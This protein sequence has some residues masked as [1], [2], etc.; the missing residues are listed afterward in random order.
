MSKSKGNVV[1]PWKAIEEFGADTI[2]WYLLSSSH[3]WLPKRFDPAGVREVHRKVFDTLRS[4]YHFFAL[5]ANLEGWQESWQDVAPGDRP[6]MDRWLLSR[7]AQVTERVCGYYEEYNLTHAAREL[8]DFVV[9]DLSNW[10]VR[11]SRDRFWGSSDSRD[12]RAAFATLHRALVDVSRLMAPIAPFLSDWLHRSL[13]GGESVHLARVP[14]VDREVRDEALEQGMEAVR[15]LATL[16]RAARETVRIRVRQPLATLYAVV[17]DDR[18]LDGELLAILRDELN[19]RQVEFMDRAEELV[20]FS[21]KPNFRALGAR[22]GKQ[23]P[24][25]AE[26][27]RGVPSA[28]LAT[29]RRGGELAVELNGDRHSILPA[30]LDIVQTARG[31]LVVEA[32][33]GF[34]AALDANITPELRAEGLAREVVNRVQRLRK[35]SGLEVADRIRLAVVGGEELVAALRAHQPFLAGE[36]LAT[37]VELGAGP[38]EEGSYEAIREVDLDGV[39]AT[40]GISRSTD[41]DGGGGGGGGPGDRASADREEG[42]KALLYSG[43]V[44]GVVGLDQ[45]TKYVVERTLIL[46]NPVPV[47]GDYLRLTYI[48]NPGAAFGLHLGDYS[49]YIFLTLTL[50]AVVLLFVWYRQTPLDDRLRLF[51][52]ATV[53]GGAVGNLIDRVRSRL[54]VV[55]FLDVGFGTV[56]WPVFNVAD[57]AVT[58]GAVLLALSLWKEEQ[59]MAAEGR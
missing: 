53:T 38:L 15:S 25:I 36:T 55:D 56:R 49:R 9:D 27:I 4:T 30:E 50:L 12:A 3:P 42:S 29:F 48:H 51:A 2:R 32:E 26:A 33:G 19:V 23:T 14:R 10:Y 35:D 47:V 11:R 20:T 44:G 39:P 22:F 43:L 46:Y 34:T 40:I 57:I 41:R 5:Y 8:G 1:D 59:A 17:P 24:A 7:L 37:S 45:L 16:G 13:T 6:I 52:I 21:A 31:E 18:A 54:G 58:V 28:E